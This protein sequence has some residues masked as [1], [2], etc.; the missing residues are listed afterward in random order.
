LG[1][2]REIVHWVQDRF[3]AEQPKVPAIRRIVGKVAEGSERRACAALRFDRRTHRYKSVRPDQAPLRQR[4][5]EIAET[6][7]RY[8]YRRIHVLLGG[9]AGR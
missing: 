5:R 2:R 9:K 1:R 7:V 8:G 4:I 6:R 3:R